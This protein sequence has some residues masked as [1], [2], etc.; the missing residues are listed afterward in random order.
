VDDDEDNEV[1][2]HPV[3]HTTVW[4]TINNQTIDIPATGDTTYIV[5]SSVDQFLNTAMVGDQNE[6]GSDSD[7][8]YF[9][10]N[11]T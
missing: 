10:G 5:P 2:P 8:E 11:L 4:Q 1:V 9:T 3:S 6:N 7:S